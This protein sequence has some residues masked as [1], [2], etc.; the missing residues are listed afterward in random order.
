MGTLV[1][2]TGAQGS[3]PLHAAPVPPVAIGETGA[4]L[5]PKLGA[6]Q[7]NALK[8]ALI[9]A[10][11]RAIG[12]DILCYENEQRAI[13]EKS[14]NQAAIALLDGK[15]ADLKNELAKTA[16]LEPSSYSTPKTRRVRITPKKPYN[17]GSILDFDGSDKKKPAY[18]A[19]GIQGDDFSMFE[20]GNRYALTI[21][22][23][24]PKDAGLGQ[25]NGYYVFIMAPADP[26]SGF[27]MPDS[28]AKGSY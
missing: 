9:A 13:R 2:P 4:T 16:L 10:T 3:S 18:Y 14:G 11:M 1:V 27:K 28:G 21:Y 23:L 26:G 7:G 20:I 25:K 6:L 22:L 12:M 19:A 8:S 24:R 15:I 17:Y 5:N